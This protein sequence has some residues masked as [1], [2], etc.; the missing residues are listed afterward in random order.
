MKL[1]IEKLHIQLKNRRQNINILFVHS[2]LDCG[3]GFHFLDM[4]KI[5]VNE[6][7]VIHQIISQI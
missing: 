7:V 3:Y 2:W 1:N 5:S 4:F 6:L